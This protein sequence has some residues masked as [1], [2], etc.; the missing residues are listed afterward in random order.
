MAQGEYLA[1]I[2][3]DDVYLPDLLEENYNLAQKYNAD[4]LKYGNQYIKHKKFSPTSI[5]SSGKLDEKTI[6]I[7]QK[8]ELG[9]KYRQLNDSDLLV[10]VW[11]GFFKTSLIK[12]HQI[13]FDTAFKHGH[14]DRVFCMQLYQHINCIIINPKIYYTHIVYKSSTS[15]VFSPDRIGDTERLLNYERKLFSTLRLNDLHPSY[16]QERV[17]TYVILTCSIVRSPEAQLSFEEVL[18]VIRG[19]REKYYAN[20]FVGSLKNVN[21]KKRLKNKVYAWL[22]EQNY[23]RILTNILLVDRKVKYVFNLLK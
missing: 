17:M 1:F 22:F 11:D 2:D 8:E 6:I 9:E 21:Y 19:L 5:C 3:N 23:L 10:Y 4:I 7:V 12:E 20:V 15:R 16:W 14:E 13:K 18:S